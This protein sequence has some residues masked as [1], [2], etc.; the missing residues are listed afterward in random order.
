MPP[1]IIVSN[2]TPIKGTPYKGSVAIECPYVPAHSEN[3]EAAAEML[4][5]QI[6]RPHCGL[7]KDAEGKQLQLLCFNPASPYLA[8]IKRQIAQ[9]QAQ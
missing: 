5:A 9:S 7:C 1:R 2:N 3:D 4:A 8:E 6:C